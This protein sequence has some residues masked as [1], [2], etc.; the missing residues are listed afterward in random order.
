[1]VD[2]FGEGGLHSPQI[3][4][5]GVECGGQAGQVVRDFFPRF[6]IAVKN[7]DCGSFIEKT[8]CGG[9]TDAA[10]SAGNQDTLAV[11]TAHFVSSKENRADQN[12]CLPEIVLSV[13]D[14]WVKSFMAERSPR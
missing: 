8:R 12:T 7:A 4:Y 1:M 13:A 14:D 9:G 11:Q 2:G 5:V 10:G 6:G 3:S